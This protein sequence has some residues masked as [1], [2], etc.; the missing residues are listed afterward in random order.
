VLR[1][2]ASSGDLAAL[3]ARADELVARIARLGG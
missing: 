1:A 3:R 2:A